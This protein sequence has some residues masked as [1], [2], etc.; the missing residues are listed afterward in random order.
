VGLEQSVVFARI[1]ETRLRLDRLLER[2]ADQ[3][4]GD[5][6]RPRLSGALRRAHPQDADIITIAIGLITEAG[7]AEGIIAEGKA[8]VVA[9][10]RG[11]LWDPRWAWHAAQELGA[12]PRIPPQYLR[13]RPQPA[14]MFSAGASGA[15]PEGGEPNGRQ[16]ET[17]QAAGFERGSCGGGKSDSRASS[18]CPPSGTGAGRGLPFTLVTGSSAG[19]GGIDTKKFLGTFRWDRGAV[20]VGDGGSWEKHKAVLK[21]RQPFTD[22]LFKRPDTKGGMRHI[23]TS[24]QPIVDDKGRF[25]GLSRHRQ[26]HHGRPARPELQSLEHSVA[27][28]IA[29]AES[30]TAAMTAAIRAICETEGWECGRY[31]RPDSEAGVLRF[32]ESWG[33]QDPA[34]QEFLERSREIVYRPGAGLMGELWQSGQ[35]LWVRRP[36]PR[37]SRTA[38]GFGADAGIRGG[39]VF[40]VRSERKVIGVFG[41]NSRQVRET[42]E[43]LLKG[44]TRDRQPDRPVFG[45]Q[46]RGRRAAPVP[47][48]DGRFRGPDASHRPDQ[49]SLCRRQ[50]RGMPGARLQP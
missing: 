43:G 33:I 40:P 32:G 39:F 6:R 41:F 9:L 20:P 23:S 30:V 26:G 19:H 21:A 25:R 28:S 10:A 31:F 46:A 50:R 22:F 5:P 14:R 3:E 15:G 8:D 13:A 47:R 44:D 24:G 48:R 27:H 29:A 45:A 36:H 37:L 16:K 2:R 17:D 49:P 38:G 35:P 4:T 7:Q 34:I 42:D 11:F 12:T 18:S 1:E